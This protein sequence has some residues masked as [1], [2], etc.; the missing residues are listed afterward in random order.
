MNNSFESL[1]K[2]TDPFSDIAKELSVKFD[3]ATINKDVQKLEE[4]IG[5]AENILFEENP[6]SQAMI[7]YSLG[8]AYDDFAKLTRN[9]NE[10]ALQKYYI[11][12]EKA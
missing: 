2:Y 1:H 12:S 11:T 9:R 5:E 7:Y 4:L 3:Y 10:N 6:A 8:T